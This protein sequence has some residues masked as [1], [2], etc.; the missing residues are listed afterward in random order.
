MRGCNE[1]VVLSTVDQ[2]NEQIGKRHS[3]PETWKIKRSRGCMRR[4]P[5]WVDIGDIGDIGI[6]GIG[7]IYSDI[8]S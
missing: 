3:K 6:G 7:S 5:P 2:N 1:Y 8:S 4:H